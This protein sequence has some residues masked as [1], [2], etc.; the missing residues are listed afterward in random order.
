MITC[1]GL[2]DTIDVAMMILLMRRPFTK[3]ML[4]TGVLR[5]AA[6]TSFSNHL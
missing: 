2:M 1:V 4:D 3:L 5:D 6:V